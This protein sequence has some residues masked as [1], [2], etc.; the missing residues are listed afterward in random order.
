MVDA[1]PGQHIAELHQR[2]H[3]F[4]LQAGGK[5]P[6]VEY[7][8]KLATLRQLVEQGG[9]AKGGAGGFAQVQVQVALGV[10]A[11][12]SPDFVVGAT[13]DANFFTLQICYRF[14]SALR[15]YHKRSDCI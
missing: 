15:R 4:G 2:L 14:N 3:A 11:Q 12:Q 1:Q 9:C 5:R 7:S 8:V 13:G 10:G 6:G